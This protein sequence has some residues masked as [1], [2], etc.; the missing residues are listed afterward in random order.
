M[1]NVIKATELGRSHRCSFNRSK[2]LILESDK[3]N[4]F[5]KSIVII[6]NIKNLLSIKKKREIT[7][8]DK[9]VVFKDLLSHFY[10]MGYQTK[11]TARIHAEDAYRQ[12]IRY[13]FCE[14]RHPR[15]G[16][17]QIIDVNGMDVKVSPDLLFFYGDT[18]EVVKLKCSKPQI[19][20]KSKIQDKGANTNLELYAMLQYAKQFIKV[21]RK[22]TIKASFYYLRKNNDSPKD[23]KF[24][25]DF[26]D[27]KGAGN[28]VSIED[29]YIGGGN[30]CLFGCKYGAAEC[31][32]CDY[33]QMCQWLTDNTKLDAEF[34]PQLE[35]FKKG[36]EKDNCTPEM[37][38]KCDF[39]HICNFNLPPQV[40]NKV[41]V[42]KSIRDLSL[43][44]AQEDAIYFRKGLCRINAGAG[45]GKTLV[46]ALR[47]A[48]M[49]A[50]GIAPEEIMLLTFTNT[51]AEEMRERVK[52]YNE[53]FGND[54]DVSA[55]RATTFNA[56]GDTII[57]EH[58]AEMGFTEEPRLIDEVE[59]SKLIIT[60]LNQMDV[61]GLDFRNFDMNTINCKGALTIA[62]K[63]F[64]IIKTKDLNIGDG[65]A[66]RNAF[67][68]D[69]R[70]VSN[71][72]AYEQLINVFYEYSALLIDNNMY[73]YADQEKLIFDY[74]HR[75]PYFLEDMNIRHIIV[76]E[77][78]DSSLSQLN[79][80]KEL[81][82]TKNFESL[83]VVGDDSQAIFSFRDTTPEYIIKFFDIMGES[84]TDMY[85]LENHR[86]TPEIINFAN[87]IN[88]INTFKVA[89]DLIATRASG[90]PVSVRGFVS[91]DEEYDYIVKGI[92]DKLENG[93]KPEDIAFI[94]SNKTE[95]LALGT[96]L[97][98][99]GIEWVMLSPEMYVEN[100][101][102]I[103][104]IEL[105]KAFDNP[106]ATK[107]MLPYLNCLYENKLLD[108]PTEEIN[109]LIDALK[110]KIY[111]IN[112]M[113]DKLALK[114]VLEMMKGID[115]EDEIYQSF[116]EKL[117]Y[118][119]S[120]SELK[121]YCSD[122]ERYGKKL[123]IRRQHDYAGVV[124]TTAH[125]SKGLE[126]PVVYNSISKY[127]GERESKQKPAREEKRRLLFVSATR[128]RDELYITGLY[129][130]FGKKDDRTY[131][132]FLKECYDA[133]EQ[134]FAPAQAYA[135]A[136][137]KKKEI[138]EMNKEASLLKKI[139]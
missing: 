137:E 97:T 49:I 54:V 92:K 80:I 139:S 120:M 83:M 61:D 70:F 84:G 87:T 76:D 28:I 126:W 47:V 123:T 88:D 5:E 68:T 9:K 104:A 94:G 56:F 74:I 106:K 111:H 39:K 21:G 13:V 90:K 58:W 119:R 115:V 77:F 53:D 8:D 99:E 135:E 117:S 86:S 81:R 129:T 12:I 52:L 1:A 11:K 65:V 110:D 34:I 62:E 41:S 133:V 51:G 138:I 91:K 118:R 98:N 26:F 103:A 112:K 43:T 36:V 40:I 24:D 18:V 134:E 95:L 122:F 33:P 50:E 107:C 46:V 132:K 17:T 93:I 72:E 60:L 25:L 108:L 37:C 75:N 116:L 30:T 23:G 22:A 31:E 44:E 42:K 82:N 109:M 16:T 102:V 63:A 105:S 128:A 124:L 15:F 113:N 32:N 38:E 59:R 121:T 127:Y 66:L 130:A 64:D 20:L 35:E 7:E 2:N 125:S 79:L 67:D 100:S 71:E 114:E 69:R 101:R 85:L 3:G 29:I 10:E 89:K 48:T 14:E 27:N 96:L 73:E 136:E 4:N 57:K 45:A 19:V 6:D 55:L 78:Q 131:N